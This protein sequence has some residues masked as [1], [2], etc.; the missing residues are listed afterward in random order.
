MLLSFTALRDA[1]FGFDW[2]LRANNNGS[3]GWKTI[4]LLRS[5]AIWWSTLW[6]QNSNVHFVSKCSGR[7]KNVGKSGFYWLRSLVNC[8]LK[9]GRL[10]FINTLWRFSPKLT[11]KLE[12]KTVSI[13]PFS[14]VI[15]VLQT[16]V[17]HL[18]GR[19]SRCIN[20]FFRFFGLLKLSVLHLLI[21]YLSLSDKSKLCLLHFKDRRTGYI[22]AWHSRTTLARASC[23]N[24]LMHFCTLCSRHLMLTPCTT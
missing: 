17:T 2:T 22:L 4:S 11:F 19:Y 1:I 24:I 18:R 6:R 16:V 10:Q 7:R 5:S 12:K 15:S 14:C 8:Y 21:Y 3:F 9:E 13:F 20:A 23:M